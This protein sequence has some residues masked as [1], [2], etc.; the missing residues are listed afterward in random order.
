MKKSFFLDYFPPPDYLAMPAVAFDISDR[1]L[2]Y[3]QIRRKKGLLRLTR[4]GREV[5]PEGLIESGEIKKEGKLVDFLRSLREKMRIE[6]VTISLPEEKGFL[7]KVR[8]PL[9][10]KSE[11]RGALEVQ[12]QENIPLSA[13]DAIF[14]FELENQ[15]SREKDQPNFMEVNLSAFPKRL[16]EV[17]RDVLKNAGFKPL[18]FEMEAQSS[19]RAIVPYGMKGSCLIVDLGKTRTTFIIVDNGEV[20]FTSTIKVGGDQFD[21]AVAKGLKL[22]KVEAEKI[23]AERGLVK[24][25]TND[26]V[27]ISLIPLVSA[28]KDE[29]SKHVK[30]WDFRK[31]R[32]GHQNKIEKIILCGGN[33]SIPGFKEYLSYESRLPVGL[34]NP[35][36]NIVSFDEYIPEINLKDSLVYATALGLALRPAFY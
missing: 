35:W 13:D 30:Y 33:S 31:K 11:I 5:I 10:D 8:L 9:M 34:A 20:Q 32:Y 22:S 6:Y 18:V 17:Y 36:V 15:D 3:A 7:S 19:A 25:K 1:S 23:K 2:K 14:D 16:V 28:I 4:F 21:I 24:N 12:L 26:E 29:I 27:F